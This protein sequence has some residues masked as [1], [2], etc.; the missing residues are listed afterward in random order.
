MN[1]TTTVTRAVLVGLGW[2]WLG[3]LAAD[4]PEMKLR[5][6]IEDCGHTAGLSPVAMGD[7]SKGQAMDGGIDEVRITTTSVAKRLAE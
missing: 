7:A 5:A 1:R 2:A 6:E 4:K 3:A